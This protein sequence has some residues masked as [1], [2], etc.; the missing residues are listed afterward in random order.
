MKT[1]S[2]KNRGQVVILTVIFFLIISVTV[3]AAVVIPTANQV[4]SVTELLRAKQGYMAAD[5]V[6]EDAWYRLSLNKTLPSTMTLPFATPVSTSATVTS[7]SGSVSIK[8]TGADGSTVRLAQST[9]SAGQSVGFPYALQTGTGGISLT[10]GAHITGDVY[11]NGSITSDSSGPYIT[12]SA[13]AA[14]NASA[15]IDQTNG[16]ADGTTPLTMSIGINASSQDASQSFQVT[17]GSLPMTAI[18][19][20]MK[21]F[22]SPANL[23]VRIVSDNAGSPGGSAL[24]SGTLN[25]SL[26]TTNFTYITLN[27]SPSLTLTPNTKYWIVFDSST[28]SSAKY[29][30]TAMTNNAYSYGVA[31]LSSGWN[32]TNGG[33]WSTVSPSTGDAYFDIFL[34]GLPNKISGASQYQRV[35]VGTAGTG[36]AWADE[37]DSATLYGTGYCFASNYMYNSGGASKYCDESRSNPTP[38][39]YPISDTQI[40]GWKNIASAGWTYNGNLTLGGGISTTTGALKINGNLTLGGGATLSITAPV[41]VTGYIDLEGG[42]KIKVP[43]SAGTSGGIIIADGRI[44]VGGGSDF[45]GSG[46]AGSYMMAISNS[47]CPY[48]GTCSGNGSGNAIDIEGGSGSVILVALNGKVSIQGGA[49]ANDVVA[50]Q[51]WVDGGSSVVYDPNLVGPSFV[52]ASSGSWKVGSWGEVSD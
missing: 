14:N 44:F 27:V 45:R 49:Q 39:T 36:F 13:V 48:S 22:G 9:F 11:T 41:W 10:G 43:S 1:K 2:S 23:T 3:I 6:N 46:T 50:K 20:Y 5:S 26:V 24:W 31:K 52:G 8:T 32:S 29:Y 17:T 25:A 16:Y 7:S 47:L 33:T 4:R 35:L 18:R 21:K 38:A 51:I 34:G 37:I 15:Y 12:G 30:V 42:S 19:L 40:T 28:A